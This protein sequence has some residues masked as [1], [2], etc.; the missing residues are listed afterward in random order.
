MG[1]LLRWVSLRR[2]I[3]AP[4]RSLLVVFGIALG[5]GT[6]V[7]TLATNRSIRA[8]FGEMSSR[9]AG[10]ADLILSNGDVGLEPELVEEIAALDGIEHVAGTVELITREPGGAGPLLILGVDFLGDRHFLPMS[11]DDDEAESIVDDPIAFVNDPDAILIAR[12]F[13]ERRQ[14]ATGQTLELL[15]PAGPRAFVVRGIL[16]DEGI[17]SAFNGQ[18]AVMFQEAA[19][20]AFGG[21]ERLE[22]IEVALSPGYEL[23]PVQARLETLLAGRGR[24]EP[25]AAR[26]RQLTSMFDSIE[27]GLQVAGA[28]A[29]LVGMFLI[30]NAVG[31]AV[32]ERRRE[33][34]LLRALG[35]TRSGVVRMFSIE[36][37][38]LS[39]FGGGLGLLLGAGMARLSL[40]Q[41]TT[42]ISRF[43]AAIQP[44]DPELT[45][46]LAIPALLAGL[47]ATVLAAWAPAR[48]AATIDPAE[49]LRRQPPSLHR[50]PLPQRAMILA[51]LLLLVPALLAARI[52]SLGGGFLAMGLFLLSALLCIPVLLLGLKRLLAGPLGRLLGAP[53]R[54]AAENA[55]RRLDRSTLTVGALMVAVSAS[56]A[57]GSWGQ[58]LER[59]ALAWLDRALPADLY[60]TAGSPVADQHN[61]PF[62]PEVMEVIEALPGVRESYPVRTVTL[63]VKDRRIQLISL[64]VEDYFEAITRKKMAPL[65]IDGPD[66]IPPAALL[67]RPSVLLSGNAARKL[68][69]RAGD[70]LVVDTPSGRKSLRVEAVILDYSSETG[71]A[72]IHR[73]WFLEYWNDPLI[74]TI[75]LLLE[76][77]ASASAVA[78]EV[79]Q[80]L[81]GGEE[82]FVISAAELRDEIRRILVDSMKIFRSTELIALIVALLGVIGTMLAAVLDRTREIGV[83]RAIGATRRQ[84]LTSVMVESAFLG[85]AATAGGILAGIPMGWVF[86][87]VVALVGTGWDFDYTFPFEAALRIGLLVTGTAALA[88][89]WPG[90]RAARME[91]PEALA[92]E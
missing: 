51:S 71:S 48:L 4:L 38:L 77:G 76:D 15:T 17:A 43:Y 25:P 46:D 6:V 39:I 12:S 28:L 33:I 57:M 91:V 66:P 19:L 86:V 22:R 85:L 60:V 27:R 5:V 87:R 89:F 55:E 3:G 81:G 9:V 18:V 74:D 32:A 47:V 80:R 14:L 79:R 59:S 40:A 50:R 90:R 26:T 92:Y 61:V 8:A 82:L 13:A 20:A 56:V 37:L 44:P 31:V 67:E 11:G 70:E 21:D 75:D 72:I 84:I 83:L 1:V 78:A 45:L 35:V 52:E 53:G 54:I 2:L 65:V 30:Y 69:V 41:A 63:D 7:A 58:S 62:R 10:K 49:S 24:V 42:P 29:L 23:A 16:R 73:R 64:D 88:G 34:G 68:E 36:A